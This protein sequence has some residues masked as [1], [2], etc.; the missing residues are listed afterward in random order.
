MVLHRRYLVRV[1][2]QVLKVPFSA[3]RIVTVPEF[4][5]RRPVKN[6]LD[7][8]TQTHR[9]LGLFAPNRKT[10]KSPNLWGS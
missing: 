2:Q 7:A 10:K 8:A 9:G 4:A 1:G 5:H 3:G 6:A